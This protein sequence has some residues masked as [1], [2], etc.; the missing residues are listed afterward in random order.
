[1]LRLRFYK[2][3]DAKYIVSWIKDEVSFRKWCADRYDKYPTTSED[4]NRYYDD[5]DAAGNFYKMTAF[6]NEVYR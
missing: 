5:A 1:M 2:K 3:S 6:D 4:M